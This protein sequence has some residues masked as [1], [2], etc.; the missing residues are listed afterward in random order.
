MLCVFVGIMLVCTNTIWVS[1]CNKVRLSH[2]LQ[3]QLRVKCIADDVMA[4]GF[5]YSSRATQCDTAPNVFS[6]GGQVPPV[7]PF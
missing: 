6:P 3:F 4:Y 2:R 5:T 1:C 7:S